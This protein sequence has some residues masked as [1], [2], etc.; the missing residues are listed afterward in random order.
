MEDPCAVE[1]FGVVAF[2]DGDP[3]LGPVVEGWVGEGGSVWVCLR[4]RTQT[5]EVRVVWV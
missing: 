4:G 1:G 3:A 5:G 2:R